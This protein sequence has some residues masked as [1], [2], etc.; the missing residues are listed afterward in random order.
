MDLIGTTIAA[1]PMPPLPLMVNRTDKDGKPVPGYANT[2]H[3]LQQAVVHAMRRDCKKENS[4][5]QQMQ[6]QLTNT[7]LATFRDPSQTPEALYS[8]ATTFTRQYLHSFMPDRPIPDA[9]F[10]PYDEIH[11]SVYGNNPL[12]RSSC[13]H[14]AGLMFYNEAGVRPYDEVLADLKALPFSILLSKYRD[15][16]ITRGVEEENNRIHQIV[17]ILE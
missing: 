15:V 10:A 3:V 6:I 5:R 16:H 14:L 9:R 11:T 8:E 12:V 13:E 7:F 1:L 17:E 4:V 2:H